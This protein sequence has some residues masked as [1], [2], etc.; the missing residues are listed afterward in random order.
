MKEDDYEDISSTSDGSKPETTSDMLKN[1]ESKVTFSE[2]RTLSLQ[3][4]LENL[5]I[6]FAEKPPKTVIGKKLAIAR[7]DRLSNMIDRRININ[8]V[9]N[10][11]KNTEYSLYD[12]Y[13]E[14]SQDLLASLSD[15][16]FS[17]ENILRQI[18]RLEQL[19]PTSKNSMFAQR[20]EQ[21]EKN[22]PKGYKPKVKDI[23]NQKDINNSKV[24][25]EIQKLQKQLQ[26]IEGEI[27]SK[28]DMLD[29]A[30]NSYLE[31]IEKNKSNFKKDLAVVKPNLFKRVMNFIKRKAEN[32]RNRRAEK[33]E[34]VQDKLDST[35][36][37]AEGTSQ[38]DM[39]LS[40]LASE[41]SQEEQAKFAAEL[42]EKMSGNT[43]KETPEREQEEEIK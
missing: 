9:K 41:Y 33:R 38:R 6:K 11:Y 27:T 30:N 29:Y 43:K 34:K 13:L 17:K 15:L 4:K 28:N 14:N 36:E 25:I 1:D 10:I 31:D 12:N 16:T 18:Q 2:K 24:G 32:Y 20:Q 21:I 8:N 40:E 42:R 35:I 5:R 26:I 19:D 22:A 3:E 23:E 7:L 37:N 39:M